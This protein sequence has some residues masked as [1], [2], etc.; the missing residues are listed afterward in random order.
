MGVVT[1][2]TIVVSTL[3]LRLIFRASAEEE[4]A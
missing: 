1:W 4:A 3:A 2:C